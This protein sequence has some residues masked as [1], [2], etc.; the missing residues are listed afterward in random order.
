MGREEAVVKLPGYAGKGKRGSVLGAS[1]CAADLSGGWNT[2]GSSK[3]WEA[4]Y[5]SF[6]LAMPVDSIPIN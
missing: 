2:F 5:L 4:L 1:E 3:V 6:G